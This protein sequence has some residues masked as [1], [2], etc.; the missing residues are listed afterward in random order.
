MGGSTEGGCWCGGQVP[1]G[2]RG[3]DSLAFRYR[4]DYWQA[5][6][7]GNYEGCRDIFGPDMPPVDAKPSSVREASSTPRS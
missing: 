1:E 2:E 5:R 3:E 4:G 6:R 7:R